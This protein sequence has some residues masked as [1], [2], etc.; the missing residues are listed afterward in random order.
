MEVGMIA[1]NQ[2]RPEFTIQI[3][4]AGTAACRL[5]GP[6]KTNVADIAKLLGK[7]PASIYK[8]FPSKAS[9]WDAIA[10]DFF[11]SD[12][13]FTAWADG[14]LA[15]VADRLK[16]TALGYHRLILNA[17]RNDSQMFKLT[18]LAAEGDWPSFRNY[19]K[20]LHNGVGELIR[21]GIAAEEFLP[22]KVDL[23]AACFCASIG[24]LLDPRIIGALPS[25]HYEFSAEELVCYS[26]SALK[27]IQPNRRAIPIS[28]RP[29]QRSP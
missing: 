14:D 12:L 25:S 24:V 2:P 7:S 9:I 6:A 1:R 8:I 16:D 28:Q 27:G 17:L 3:V 10:E 19:L 4:E 23:A 13:C 29:G 15:S 22:T 20:R 26:V 18:V 21:A 11:E 5:Y